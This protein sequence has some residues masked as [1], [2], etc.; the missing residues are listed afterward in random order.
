MN[1][2][3]NLLITTLT[4]LFFVF[5]IRKGY[6]MGF[7]KKLLSIAS[8]I[9]AIILTKALYINVANVTNDY[10]NIIPNIS[11]ALK[12][13]FNNS[14]SFDNIPIDGAKDIF[15]FFNMNESIN[16]ISDTLAKGIWE[17][18]C[19]IITFIAV[20]LLLKIII[21]LLDFIDFVPVIG[22]LNKILGGALGIVEAFFILWIL[23]LIIRMLTIVPQFKVVEDYINNSFITSSV[24]NNN[25][26][27]N[28]FVNL[29]K[30]S[31]V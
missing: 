9:I 6:Q 8:L 10:T 4:I 23:F 16:N 12:N 30:G 29:F 28:F 17:V 13:A 26:I 1:S 24:Y 3:V 19:G 20:M 22:K 11:S 31:S 7:F 27:Y 5:S 21:R 15:N 25:F 18:V 2:I 14:S